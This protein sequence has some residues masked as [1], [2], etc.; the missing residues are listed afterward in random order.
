MN[1][2]RTKDAEETQCKRRPWTPGPWSIDRTGGYYRL[3]HEGNTR[4]AT[5]SCPP[6][7]T[8]EEAAT[9]S[10]I[11]A[12]PELFE[13]LEALIALNDDF[14]P[15]GGELF[16]DR[17]ERTWEHARSVLAKALGGQDA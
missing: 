13:A 6:M 1:E 5:F 17:V 10:L 15:F 7:R 4:I 11:A 12:A 14:S 8:P 9:H 3:Y 2:D 16:R